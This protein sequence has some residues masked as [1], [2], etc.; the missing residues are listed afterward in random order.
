M[1]SVWLPG[2]LSWQ[3][4]NPSRARQERAPWIRENCPKGHVHTSCPRSSAVLTVHRLTPILRE[5]VQIPL[6][7]PHPPHPTLFPS[8]NT[9]LV[10]LG[11][12]GLQLPLRAWGC[13]R[14]QKQNSGSHWA[15][16][17]AGKQSQVPGSARGGKC[18]EAKK[19]T[20]G[21]GRVGW[22]AC[23]FNGQVRRAI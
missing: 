22:R 15:H 12:C 8:P 1:D 2:A 3:D 6:S 18:H 7:Q 10:L 17:L 19:G 14:E 13:P 23:Y 16:I 5:G 9:Q 11:H 21:E 20:M 4:F